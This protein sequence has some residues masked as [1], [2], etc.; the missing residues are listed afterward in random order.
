MEDKLRADA[1]RE[2]E[3]VKQGDDLAVTVN[4]VVK[5][6]IASRRKIQ[7]G[8]KLAGR[9]GNKGVVAKIL[10]RRRH[11]VPAGRH[12]ARTSCSRRWACPRA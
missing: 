12:A 6:Y 1:A 10:P 5:V 2:K 3:N 8:D 4:K 11:A 9:H 7:V